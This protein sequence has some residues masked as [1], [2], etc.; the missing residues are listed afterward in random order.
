MEFW[1]ELNSDAD[2]VMHNSAWSSQPVE[3]REHVFLHV[4]PSLWSLLFDA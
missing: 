4:K 2:G 3:L 1:G